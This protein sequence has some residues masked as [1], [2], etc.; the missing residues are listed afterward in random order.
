MCWACFRGRGSA[1]AVFTRGKSSAARWA[2]AWKSAT[3]RL[4]PPD[5]VPERV[6]LALW[7]RPP[8]DWLLQLKRHGPP[9]VVRRPTSASWP[10]QTFPKS[11]AVRWPRR[12]KRVI[13]QIVRNAAEKIGVVVSGM[14]NVL[15]P[16][17]V[18]L[19]AGLVEAIPQLF[20]DG[21]S[22]AVRRHVLAS[23]ADS[24]RIVPAELGDEA[25][26]MG[27]PLGPRLSE[28]RLT[29]KAEG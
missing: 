22:E 17:V 25:I 4:C 7:K 5:H 8:A 26:V 14:I 1:G 18:V 23:Y 19:S 6:R 24:Y 3:C 16:D 27:Q 12:L 20:L 9:F 2:P 28:N 21:V 15:A 10:E 29:Q 13:E 11:A